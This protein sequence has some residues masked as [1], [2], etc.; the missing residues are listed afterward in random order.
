MEPELVAEEQVSQ[1]PESPVGDRPWIARA[2]LALVLLVGYGHYVHGI[3]TPRDF[4]WDES[5]HVPSAQKYLHG[6]FYMESH[7]PLGKLLIALGR[8]LEGGKGRSAHFIDTDRATWTPEAFDFTP[9]RR[10]PAVL[11]WL[12]TGLLF[13][14]FLLLTRKVLAAFSLSML[15]GLDNAL[16]VH[17]RGAM[18]EGP[19]LFFTTLAILAFLLLLEWRGSP[20]RSLVAALV[21]GGACGLALA[22]KLLGLISILLLPAAIWKRRGGLRDA[23]RIVGVFIVGFLA[24]SLA[25]WVIHFRL[26]TKI[27]ENLPEQGFYGASQEHREILR[28]GRGGSLGA[29]PVQLTDAWRFFFRHQEG[30][31]T[32]NLC[33]P[34]EN[35]SPFFFWPL[36]ARSINYRWEKAGHEQ[37]RYVYL[38]GNPAVWLAGLLGVL[39]AAGL[40]IV[41]WLVHLQAPLRRPFLLDTFLG[42][43]LAYLLAVSQ[44]DRVMYLYHYFLP[45]LFSFVLLALAVGEIRR[46]G[47]LELGNRGR[48]GIWGLLLVAVV[49]GFVIYRPLTFYQPLTREQ[50][51]WRA[52]FPLWELRC[53]DCPRESLLVGPCR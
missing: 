38:Q 29:L 35:G 20:R 34:G 33:K 1:R 16:I 17:Q 52:W 19:L 23:L 31:E 49:A 12:T 15:Y 10:V 14:V 46:L 36:G 21:L 37:H 28:A 5:Y 51:E 18:L 48:N 27:N 7:P 42:L 39:L 53:A 26:A 3:G 32:L 43:Y 22:T 30:V 47:P 2:A 9:Y 13:A 8:K 45:L 24:A 44:I 6:V 41:S 40:R 4:F 50:V 25:V 11:A